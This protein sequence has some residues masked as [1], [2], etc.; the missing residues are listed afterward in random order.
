VYCRE[1]STTLG[2]NSFSRTEVPKLYFTT[3][4]VDPLEDLTVDASLK[5]IYSVK[6]TDPKDNSVPE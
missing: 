5:V 3:S 1:V 4:G 6:M 2:N